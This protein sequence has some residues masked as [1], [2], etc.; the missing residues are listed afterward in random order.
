MSLNHLARSASAAQ[1]QKQFFRKALLYLGTY[2]ILE[3]SSLCCYGGF[4]PL[5][6]L[7]VVRNS[8]QVEV[9]ALLTYSGWPSDSVI[10]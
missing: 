6:L 7:S 9:V 2:L 10:K 4:F 8:S 1:V 5:K 3:N